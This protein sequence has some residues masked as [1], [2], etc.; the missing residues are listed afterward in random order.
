MTTVAVIIMADIC[1]EVVRQTTL[2]HS[3]SQALC[4]GLL[5]ST[6][7]HITSLP[8]AKAPRPILLPKITRCGLNPNYFSTH[9]LLSPMVRTQLK[10]RRISCP[11][12]YHTVPSTKWTISS[13]SRGVTMATTINIRT[14]ISC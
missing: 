12:P 5:R 4:P 13:S 1:R 3:I 11:I 6:S 10:T 9:R 7:W 2:Q 8:L 14:L